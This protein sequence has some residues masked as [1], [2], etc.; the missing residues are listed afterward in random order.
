MRYLRLL[1]RQR[2]GDA[3]MGVDEAAE[4][5]QLGTGLDVCEPPND[6]GG[7][8]MV[9]EVMIF[10]VVCWGELVRFVVVCGEAEELG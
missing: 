10:D 9:G 4:L 3:M 6:W 7:V 2:F 1:H 8:V 5:A